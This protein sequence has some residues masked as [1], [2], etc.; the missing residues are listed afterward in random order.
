MVEHRADNAGVSGSIPLGPTIYFVWAASG[1]DISDFCVYRKR[2]SNS[3]GR[4]PA[5]QAGCQEFNSPLLHF[6]I[7]YQ[8]RLTN[9]IIK[10]GFFKKGWRSF[11]RQKIFEN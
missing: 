7:R 4:M 3:V 11:N 5:L 9:F 10:K 1:F 2:G 6:K 8:S